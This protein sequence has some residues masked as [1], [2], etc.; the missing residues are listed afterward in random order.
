MDAEAMRAALPYI[1]EKFGNA[2]SLHS[3]GQEAVSA[4]DLSR[5]TI[6]RTV[7]AEFRQIIFTSSATEANNLALRGALEKFRKARAENSRARVILSP[8]EHESAKDTAEAL[9]ESG[10]E[11]MYAPVNTEGF[12]DIGALKNLINDKTALVSIMY[13]NNE[14]GTVEPIKEISEM[15][16]FIRKSRDSQYPLFHSDAA[17]AFQFFPCNVGELGVDFLT[18]SA[19]KIYGPKGIGALYV[20][21]AELLS[22]ITTGGGQE[23]GMRPGTENIAGAVGFAKAALIVS[24]R[25][26]KERQRLFDLRNY[27][28]EKLRAGIADIEIN[29]P[30]CARD[31]RENPKRAPNNLNIY[32]RN[33]R[34]DDLVSRLDAAGV[35]ISSG[36]ACSARSLE[37]SYV[38]VACGLGKERAQRSVRLT[39]GAPTTKR[40]I[41]EAAKRVI[42]CLKAPSSSPA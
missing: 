1:R 17:Q 21:N 11:I 2:G 18:L 23:F 41:D 9:R 32:F 29:G 42:M 19:Q 30:D 39:L 40:E 15:I 35:A 36:S 10:A 37:P 16:S 33:F 7:G 20:K 14:I 8:I 6:A 38:I 22:P 31:S 26:E 27:L 13:V 12:V 28:W 34:A 3:F 24:E 25:R 4:L 5:E